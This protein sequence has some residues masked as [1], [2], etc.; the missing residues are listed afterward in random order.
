[1]TL[2]MYEILFGK[3]GCGVKKKHK[4]YF[5]SQNRGAELEL[6][7][8]CKRLTAIGEQN[9]CEYYADGYD[10]NV[11]SGF[12]NTDNAHVCLEKALDYY[13]NRV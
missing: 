1:M 8:F 9:T 10:D 11:C 12:L 6:C 3:R 2:C 4:V 7:M 13:H 5:A